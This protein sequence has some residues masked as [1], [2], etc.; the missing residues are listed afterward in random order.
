MPSISLRRIIALVVLA[1]LAGCS[2]LKKPGDSAG[3][4]EHFY[5]EGL[6][7]LNSGAYNRAIKNFQILDARYPYGAYA[8]QAQI[9]IAYAYYKNNHPNE[10]IDA[11]DRFIRLHPTYQYV[12]YAYYLKGLANFHFKH[13]T[14]SRMFA[15]NDVAD[16]D[17]K[18]LA[19][20]YDSFRVVVNRFPGSRYA[21]DSRKRMAYLLNLMARS[22][23][24]IARF[25]LKRGAYVAAANRAK[26][27]I[28][29]YQRTPAVE[30]ALGIQAEA[31]KRMGMIRL[32][33]DTLRVL[34]LNFPGS[35]YIGRIKALPA[36]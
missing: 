6:S 22:E 34:Q 36:G 8:E 16:R 12:D 27:V 25:Y 7:A 26:Y 30:E 1:L 11:A 33:D 17:T 23:L 2:T 3:S 20:A 18:R 10:A 19:N 28:D 13:S 32:A 15:G 24:N 14:L 21:A 9:D 35:P 29:H 4:P 5:N 31:Y